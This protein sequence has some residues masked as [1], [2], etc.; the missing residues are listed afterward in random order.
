MTDMSMNDTAIN[1]NTAIKLDNVLNGTN[2]SVSAAAAEETKTEQQ[3]AASAPLYTKEYATRLKQD[4]ATKTSIANFTEDDKDIITRTRTEY[5]SAFKAGMKRT[6]MSVLATCR[7][8]YEA[9]LSLSACDFA[10]FCSD[11]GYK[12]DSAAIRKFTVIGKLYPR[13]IHAVDR[14]PDSW[15]SIYEI[16]QIPAFTFESM[17]NGTGSFRHIKGSDL[18]ALINEVKPR[19]PIAYLLPTDKE[20][21]G[22]VFGKLQFTK[23]PDLADWRAMR[24]ALAEIES[25]LPIKFM[26]NQ[27]AEME[28]EKGRNELY[29]KAKADDAGNELKP[30]TWDFGREADV[31]R[32]VENDNV[33]AAEEKQAS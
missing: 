1:S 17:L 23:Q 2:V 20:T 16:T 14:L 27:K 24:K 21:K 19:T 31:V 32:K 33:A 29:A 5:V 11:V 3:A 12:E 22:F 8:V 30:D 4:N 6:A 10:D 18:R 7:V 25:R 26:F 15:T 28:W 13:L 9:K